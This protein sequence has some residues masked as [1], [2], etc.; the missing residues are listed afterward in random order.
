[1]H[2]GLHKGTE[3]TQSQVHNQIPPKHGRQL[4]KAEDLKHTAQPAGGMM[5]FK[6]PFQGSPL[7]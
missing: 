7:V 5:V 6:C 1:M 4:A 3:M 2:K